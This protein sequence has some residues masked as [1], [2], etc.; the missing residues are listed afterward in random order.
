MSLPPK[1]GFPWLA[2]GIVTLAVAAMVGLGIW[3]L[4]IRLPQKLALI[5]RFDAAQ[6]APIMPYA[7]LHATPGD[8]RYRRVTLA[9]ARLSD[10]RAVGGRNA[11]GQSGWAHWLTCALPHASVIVVAGWSAAPAPI[12]TP[13]AGAVNGTLIGGDHGW[14]DRSPERVV[15]DPP[16][17]GLQPNARPDPRE[18]PNNHFAYAIQWFLFAATATV[19]YA[20][21]LWR[22]LAGLATPR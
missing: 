3:Q 9:C 1:L 15:A 8:H 17:A 10:D 20:I 12:A 2:T 21:A 5:A 19:I 4:A 11:A 6:G 13:A 22:R 14:G 7:Q 16:L 18:L